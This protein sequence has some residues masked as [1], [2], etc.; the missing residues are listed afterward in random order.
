[1]DHGI[2]FI[3]VLIEILIKIIKRLKIKSVPQYS[4]LTTIMYC[5]EMIENGNIN[6]LPI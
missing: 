1:M 4:P 5:I 3:P 2:D 6:A